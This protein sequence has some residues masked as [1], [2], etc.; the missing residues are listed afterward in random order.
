MIHLALFLLFALGSHCS[1]LTQQD[2]TTILEPQCDYKWVIQTGGDKVWSAIPSTCRDVPVKRCKD[3]PT[4]GR[5]GATV[6]LVDSSTVYGTVA[7]TLNIVYEY[8]ELKITGNVTGLSPG[9]HGFHIHEKGL[10]SNNC[11]DAGGHFNPE[12]NNHGRPSD[13]ERHAGDLGNINADDY[14]VAMVSKVDRHATFGDGGIRDIAG[15]AIVI[16]EDPD[17]FTGK[18]GNAG[19][20]AGCGFIPVR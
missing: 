17:S 9:E 11:A 3:V 16:H 13:Y 12:N 20:R 19:A 18:T 4:G 10:L 7:G 2:C 1:P 8:G 14:G 5:T 6:T 15:R